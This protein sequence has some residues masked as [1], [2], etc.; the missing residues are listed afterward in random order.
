[1]GYEARQLDHQL[2]VTLGDILSDAMTNSSGPIVV[3]AGQLAHFI[4]E[5]SENLT[6]WSPWAIRP[7]GARN[8][9]WQSDV[10]SPSTLLTELE[11][12]G[13][14]WQYVQGVGKPAD[15]FP[16]Y[17]TGSIHEPAPNDVDYELLPPATELRLYS[18]DL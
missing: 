6:Y 17:P 9:A 5:R 8:G 15:A 2:V 13:L 12:N 10:P 1:M 14:S 3:D 11:T 18:L 16:Q 4:E 7:A